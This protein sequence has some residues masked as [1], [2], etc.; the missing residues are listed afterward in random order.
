MSFRLQKTIF[1]NPNIPFNKLGC[2][3]FKA[4]EFYGSLAGFS[5][6]ELATLP[7]GQINAGKFSNRPI[8]KGSRQILWCQYV[9]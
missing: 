8:L 9:N 6:K 7:G 2:K 3:F 1:K 5:L 4:A